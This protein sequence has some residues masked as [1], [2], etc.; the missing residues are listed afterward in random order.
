[1]LCNKFVFNFMYG[2]FLFGKRIENLCYAHTRRICELHVGAT[3]WLLHVHCMLTE[4]YSC[5]VDI[6]YL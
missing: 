4:D 6:I 1:M 5:L 2:A 3:G